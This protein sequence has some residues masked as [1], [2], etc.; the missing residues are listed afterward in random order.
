MPNL[1]NTTETLIRSCVALC[2]SAQ[3]TKDVLGD[4]AF[5]DSVRFVV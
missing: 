4:T 3:T 1:I 5:A 2:H